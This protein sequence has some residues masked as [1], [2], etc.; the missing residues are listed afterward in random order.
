MGPS[1]VTLGQYFHKVFVLLERL[2][3]SCQLAREQRPLG[4]EKQSTVERLLCTQVCPYFSFMAKA[5]LI[6]YHFLGISFFF[7]K[8]RLFFPLQIMNFIFIFLF[9]SNSEFNFFLNF[10]SNSEF[11]YYF[12]SNF[13]H[14]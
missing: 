5:T 1:V 2:V 3:R 14:I 8:F 12:L 11:H 7:V 13:C 6:L 9:L 4:V 10:L